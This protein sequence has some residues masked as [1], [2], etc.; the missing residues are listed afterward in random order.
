[1]L[2]A[3]Q[4]LPRLY[5]GG[6]EHEIFYDPTTDRYVKA[7]LPNQFGWLPALARTG[8]D[9]VFDPA[10]PAD[11]FGRIAG[12]NDVFGDQT[13]FEGIVQEANGAV[14]A[15]VS[16]P[17]LRGGEPSLA[18]VRRW[19]ANRGFMEVKGLTAH[20]LTFYD[21]E[22]NIGVFDAHP[23]NFKRSDEGD[24]DPIDV[25]VIQPAGRMRELLREHTGAKAR[26]NDRRRAW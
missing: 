13:H 7:T 2:P 11:Y 8:D 16:Q 20:G 26:F 23:A 22:Q 14:R 3:E 25:I 6:T 10:S 21:P 5:P 24:I 1:M 19:M 4:I 17:A 9:L 18:E 15:V 12:Q